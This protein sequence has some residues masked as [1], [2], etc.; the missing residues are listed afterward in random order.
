M[1]RLETAEYL[2]GRELFSNVVKIKLFMA[3]TQSYVPIDLTKIAGNVY[4][5][6]LTGALLLE[7]INLKKNWIWDVL[8]VD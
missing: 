7:N 3:D 6:K 4:M 1:I 2:E 5:F 8:E